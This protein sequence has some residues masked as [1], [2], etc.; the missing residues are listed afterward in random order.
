MRAAIC[1]STLAISL[2]LVERPLAQEII[3]DD[4]ASG[5]SSH[6]LTA[7]VPIRRGVTTN[8]RIVKDFIDLVPFNL[9]SITGGGTISGI[10]NGKTGS[11]LAGKGFIEMNVAVPATQGLGSTITLKVGLNDQFKFRAV[12]RGLVTSITKTPDPGTIAPGTAWTATVQGTD[13]GSPVL[14]SSTPACHTVTVLN[15]T[16]TS[17]QFRLQ[18]QNCANTS[19]TFA[20][21]KGSGANEAPSYPLSNGVVS[22]F[23]FQYDPGPPAGQLCASQASIGAPRITAPSAGQT[24]VF[25]GG[26]ASPTNILIRWDSLTN[27]LTPAPNNEWIVTRR[28]R[29]TRSTSLPSL[30]FIDVSTVVRG[31]SVSLPFTIPGSHTVTIRAKNCDISAPTSSLTFSTVVQ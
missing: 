9:V 11:G 30:A 16:N 23:G 10:K 12:H 1:L 2:V 15:R 28:V 8:V 14:G 17:A 18:K 21:V 27:S 7:T 22:G 26:T 25:G 19:F 3:M 31:L 4:F 5:K 29:N 24:L 20:L 6:S 13:L